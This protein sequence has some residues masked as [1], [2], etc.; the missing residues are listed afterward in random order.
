[1]TSKKQNE[2]IELR[3]TLNEQYPYIRAWGMTLKSFD[4]YIMNEQQKAARLGAPY[5]ACYYDI[6]KQRWVTIND[7]ESK[8]T[9]QQMNDLVDKIKGV[10]K[11]DD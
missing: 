4:Y 9:V 7:V 10:K 1:M 8:S 6:D 3:K 5:N 11:N 2:K